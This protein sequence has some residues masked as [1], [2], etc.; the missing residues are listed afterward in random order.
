MSILPKGSDNS[1]S[2]A[3]RRAVLVNILSPHPWIAWAT[4]LGPLTITTGRGSVVAGAA[5]VIGFYLA[6]VAGKIVIALLVA[7]GRRRLG[8]T[9][10]RRALACAGGL[11]VL[12]GVVM[13]VQFADYGA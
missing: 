7:R 10:Y 12:V 9:G 5:L 13:G 11:L 6:M 3:F 4:A 2:L 1:G 8:D